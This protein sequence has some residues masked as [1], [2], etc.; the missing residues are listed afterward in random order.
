MIMI[1]EEFTLDKQVCDIL[2]D[3]IKSSQ[4]HIHLHVGFPTTDPNSNEVVS[5]IAEYG[6]EELFSRLL[7]KSV[8]KRIEI[9][10]L[11]YYENKDF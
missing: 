4:A 7:N 1:I 8:N 10:S 5:V 6:D 11:K 3:E 9:E 2:Q